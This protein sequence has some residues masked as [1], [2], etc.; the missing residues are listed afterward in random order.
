MAVSQLFSDFGQDLHSQAGPVSPKN[1]YAVNRE[2]LSL[3]ELS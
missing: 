2:P 1:T 3:V